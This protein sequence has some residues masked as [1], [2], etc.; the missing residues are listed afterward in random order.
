MPRAH[1]F[2]A[3]LCRSPR[4]GGLWFQVYLS[5]TVCEIPSQWKKAGIAV[6]TSSP[7]NVGKLKMGDSWPTWA[8]T[9]SKTLYPK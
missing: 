8:W 7:S 5:K 1:A 3:R 2:T 9:K 6:H 4:L